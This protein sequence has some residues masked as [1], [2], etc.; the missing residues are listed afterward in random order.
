MSNPE[1]QTRLPA[2]ITIVATDKPTFLAEVRGPMTDDLAW[3]WCV[4]SPFPRM[5]P[6]MD[7][8]R[9]RIHND[10]WTSGVSSALF[11]AEEWDRL[12]TAALAA[13]AR[14]YRMDL[15]VPTNLLQRHMHVLGDIAWP[16]VELL[17]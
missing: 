2:R 11:T 1:P 12:E 5:R 16:H 10:M 4:K 13:D 17:P 15:L 6:S 7:A 9:P 3:A 14:L 8:P